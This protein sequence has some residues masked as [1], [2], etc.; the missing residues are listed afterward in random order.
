MIV[1]EVF[2]RETKKTRKN[3]ASAMNAV[4]K[5]FPFQVAA[6]HASA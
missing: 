1:T 3:L 4:V 6:S 5:N 2:E